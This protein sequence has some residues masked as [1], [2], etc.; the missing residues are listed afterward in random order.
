MSKCISG[1]KKNEKKIAASVVIV[2]MVMSLC[3]GC[4]G[5][6]EPSAAKDKGKEEIVYWNIGTENPDKDI[7]KYAVDKFNEKTDSGY[8]VTSEAIQNDTYKEKLVI[9]MSADECPDVYVTWVGGPMKEYIEAGYA[10]PIQDLMDA[11]PVK[12]RIIDS[13]IE[14][15]S[16]NGGNCFSVCS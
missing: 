13:A 14:Q 16:Y 7:L 3:A 5:K 4:S 1:R 11:S 15:S 2:S 10:Q 8:H 9:S 12:D 6:D